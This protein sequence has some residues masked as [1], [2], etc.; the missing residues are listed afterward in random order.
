MT[1]KRLLYLAALLILCVSCGKDPNEEWSRF[2]GFTKTDIVGHYEANP[3]PCVY[4]EL[5]TEGVVVYDNAT[6]EVIDLSDNLVSF[7]LVIPETL[8]KVFTGSV[9]TDGSSSDLGF[10]NNH[11]DVLLTVYKNGKGQV[12]FH[13]RYRYYYSDKGGPEDADIYGFDVIKTEI[14]Q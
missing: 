4:P 7:R 8:N 11:E 1:M 13:G 3:D 9:P 6:V 2:F 14:Q 5:P 10:H 12:R